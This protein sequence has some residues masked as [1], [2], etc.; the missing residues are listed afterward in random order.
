MLKLGRLNQ[1]NAELNQLIQEKVSFTAKWD[2]RNLIVE[3]EPLLENLKNT[4]ADLRKK[5]A[6]EEDNIPEDKVKSFEKEAE[7]LLNKEVKLKGKINLSDL[8]SLTSEKVYFEIYNV[9]EK[10]E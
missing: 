3:V 9:V 7:K 6:D 10:D 1:L 5:Y 4:F 8:K 2:V